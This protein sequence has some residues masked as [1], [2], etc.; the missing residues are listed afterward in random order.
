MQD[1]S[2]FWQTTPCPSW[3]GAKHSV[4][5]YADDRIHRPADK[6][7]IVPL[8]IS[9]PIPRQRPDGE[10]YCEPPVLHIDLEQ[11]IREIGPRI[12]LA[13]AHSSEFSLT[14]TEAV[15]LGQALLTAGQLAHETP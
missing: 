13:E 7:A 8:T 10:W 1:G 3:C 11:H 4:G 6:V 9:N 12:V 15:T 5:D 14:A 2:P